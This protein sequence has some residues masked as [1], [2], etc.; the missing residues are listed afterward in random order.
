M[1]KS[2]QIQLD[3][4]AVG[5]DPLADA[6]VFTESSPTNLGGIVADLFEKSTDAL[7]V[8][9]DID[10]RKVLAFPAATN[11]AALFTG[12]DKGEIITIVRD[13]PTKRSGPCTAANGAD[14]GDASAD[15]NGYGSAL[16][17][18]INGTSKPSK[19]ASSLVSAV[20]DAIAA[21][22]KDNPSADLSGA[23]VLL[24]QT[25]DGIVRVYSKVTGLSAT[26]G[27]V[28]KLK[29]VIQATDSGAEAL[30]WE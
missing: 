6:V 3:G 8:L 22:Q 14:M 9:V 24:D 15:D 10:N 21:Y 1:A 18:A 20:E 30:A 23:M 4:I 27:A 12:A 29:Q 11:V 2:G 25:G 5:T 13:D 26:T 17:N 28:A 19:N 7:R 16:E